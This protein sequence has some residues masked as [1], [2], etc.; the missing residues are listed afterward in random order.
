MTH[1]LPLRELPSLP[2]APRSSSPSDSTW[3]V[4]VSAFRD[5]VAASGELAKILRLDMERARMIAMNAPG[6]LISG[7]TRIRAEQIAAAVRELGVK[8]RVEDALAPGPLSS[9]PPPAA[10]PVRPA[11]NRPERA[12]RDRGGFW[13]QV[14]AAFLAPFLGQGSLLLLSAGLAGV[15][16]MGALVIPFFIV[17][18]L[19]VGLFFALAATGIVYETFDRLAQSAT[20]RDDDEWV[21]SPISRL[22]SMMELCGRGLA[23]SFVSGLVWV[24]MAAAAPVLADWRLFLGLLLVSYLY[25]PMALT[26]MSI[27]GTV[28]GLLDVFAI[29]RGIA[30]APLEYLVVCVASFAALAGTTVAVLGAMG[31]TAGAGLHAGHG[32]VG[33]GL[34]VFVAAFA[35]YAGIAYLH[36]VLGYLMGSLVRAKSE[37]FEFLL[38]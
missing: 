21:G 27:R 9:F 10:K 26:V 30:A 17:Y 3:L 2:T 36:G 28:F 13:L 25:W 14:P 38:A 11:P 12:P 31:V 22:P 33:A 23:V 29:V 32:L 34:T 20:L 5:P 4:R 18:K 35:Y 1:D 19:V 7:T 16:V 24:G 15:A 8:A 37:R 6:V